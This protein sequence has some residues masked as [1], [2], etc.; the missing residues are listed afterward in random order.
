MPGG[1]PLWPGKAPN[2][3]GRPNGEAARDVSLFNVKALKAESLL[4][5]IW[6]VGHRGYF[7]V[8]RRGSSML[9]KYYESFT[10]L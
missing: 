8:R 10:I 1:E 3:G 5:S 4:T 7:K 2:P 6:I 9:G